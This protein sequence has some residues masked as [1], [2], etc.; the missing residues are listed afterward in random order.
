MN[1]GSFFRAVLTSLDPKVDLSGWSEEDVQQEAQNAIL[2][3]VRAFAPPPMPVTSSAFIPPHE[4][5]YGRSGYNG[6]ACAG[7]SRYRPGGTCEIVTG[8]ID[9]LGVCNA[10]RG[11]AQDKPLAVSLRA[12][13]KSRGQKDSSGKGSPASTDPDVPDQDNDFN[14]NAEASDRID[15]EFESAE[16]PRGK[17][18][19]F[20]KKGSGQ[21]SVATPTTS[22]NAVQITDRQSGLIDKRFKEA[23][24]LP[25]VRQNLLKQNAAKFGLSMPEIKALSLYSGNDDYIA[26]NGFLRGEKFDRDAGIQPETAE[27]LATGVESALEK[28][29]SL[30]RDALVY[31]SENFEDIETAIAKYQPGETVTNQFFT[32]TS[33]SVK[34]I[35]GGN[36][37][38]EIEASKDGNG[39]NVSQFGL[40]DRTQKEVL[41]QRG[42]QFEVLSVER[43]NSNVPESAYYDLRREYGK[44]EIFKEIFEGPYVDYKGETQPGMFANY[45]IQTATHEEFMRNPRDSKFQPIMEDLYGQLGIKVRLREVVEGKNRRDNLSSLVKPEDLLS[46]IR[47]VK[48]LRAD[49]K[50]FE[51][52][53][54]GRDKNGRFAKKK[55]AEVSEP[56]PQKVAAKL[57]PKPS[58]PLVVY[59]KAAREMMERGE[60]LVDEIVRN[61]PGL[62]TQFPELHEKAKGLF[63]KRVKAM[64]ALEAAKKSED[65]DKLTRAEDRMWRYEQSVNNAIGNAVGQMRQLLFNYSEDYGCTKEEADDLI[66][67]QELDFVGSATDFSKSG[68][69]NTQ[70]AKDITEQTLR[71]FYNTTGL[72]PNIEKL[73]IDPTI[74]RSYCEPSENSLT[75]G[76]KDWVNTTTVFHEAAH[77]VETQNPEILEATTAFLNSRRQVDPD[78]GKPV[79]MSLSEHNSNYRAHEKAWKDHLISPYAGKHY[80][81]GSKV[82]ATELVSMGVERLANARQATILFLTDPDHFMLMMGVLDTAQSKRRDSQEGDRT[83]NN[84]EFEESKHQRDNR[85]RFAKKSGGGSALPQQ[86]AATRQA[87]WKREIARSGSEGLISVK[88]SERQFGKF[89]YGTI[90]KAKA[91]NVFGEWEDHCA[92]MRDMLYDFSEMLE[93]NP[94]LILATPY[95]EMPP[96]RLIE[97]IEADSYNLDNLSAMALNLTPV[98]E[99]DEDGYQKALRIITVPEE[100]QEEPMLAIAQQFVEDHRNPGSYRRHVHVLAGNPAIL[101]SRVIETIKFIAPEGDPMR[102]YVEQL[103][104]KKQRHGLAGVTAAMEALISESFDLGHNGHM[105]CTPV[106]ARVGTLYRKMGFRQSVNDPF[107]QMELLPEDAL[108]FWQMR[109]LN[110]Q[111]GDSDRSMTPEEARQWQA[112]LDELEA[113]LNGGALLMSPQAKAQ[114]SEK[115]RDDSALTL[116]AGQN[117]WDALGVP[118]EPVK[119]EEQIA[120]LVATNLTP[121]IEKRLNTLK[122]SVDKANSFKALLELVPSLYADMDRGAS[123]EVIYQGFMLANLSG[124]LQVQEEL[125]DRDRLDAIIRQDAPRVPEYLRLEFKEAREY[126]KRKVG[127]PSD[128]WRD[129]DAEIHEFAYTVA[130]L[131]DASLLEDMRWLINYAEAEGLGFEEFQRLFMRNIYRKGWRP[132]PQPEEGKEDWRL[133]VAFETPIRRS[134]SAGRNQ[135]MADPEVLEVCPGRMWLHTSTPERYKEEY[136]NARLHHLALHKKVFPSEHRFWQI[137][138]PSCDY[139]CRC[140]SVL[141]PGWK[142]ERDG[143][144]LSEPPD[145]LTV[146][147]KGFTRSAGTVPKAEQE[148]AAKAVLPRLSPDIRDQVEADLKDKG[149]IQ[150]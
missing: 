63:E 36:V 138:A 77:L 88:G 80:S 35:P 130:G 109:Q 25:K 42:T 90:S 97:A 50:K 38:I 57:Q 59:E 5:D 47:A 101:P 32:S 41:F 136:P 98:P 119:L 64:N 103:E 112:E 31:R 22:K 10:W 24:E 117:R 129:F 87:E 79:L 68:V 144:E 44:A 61:I 51:E 120:G 135:Q 126:L 1:N 107:E 113:E 100:S 78:T 137:A 149:I 75:I 95:G 55:S 86:P 125:S 67:S 60:S 49:A 124:R 143:I 39:K 26:I 122:A 85:G 9:P 84:Q 69:T 62:D 71:G 70:T 53:E 37:Q 96:E 139:L 141:V 4:V 94:E 99:A 11:L 123:S 19:R 18:G 12:D 108:R 6:D 52:R 128:S 133:R 91:G 21:G 3:I 102:D 73:R 82:Y 132:G 29:P 33:H 65:P 23:A 148:A 72:K 110:K 34:E 74:Q 92:L 146:A 81:D 45:G 54:H 93:D 46:Q 116:L 17:D 83:D 104:R 150:S 66:E 147:G 118:S 15:E 20:A 89:H 8:K 58:K 106:D 13:E 131:T 76:C 121:H 134:I 142:M 111:R 56:K 105:A 7:C 114:L 16:H 2:F 145:P 115:R 27:A 14:G 127:I 48:H 140:H 43:K 40:L 28:L 30:K